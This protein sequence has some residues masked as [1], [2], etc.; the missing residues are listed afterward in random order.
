MISN[1]DAEDILREGGKNIRKYYDNPQFLKPQNKNIGSNLSVDWVTE[2][3][4]STQVL[5]TRLFRK[6]D[7]RC[8]CMGEEGRN[9]YISRILNPKNS[10]RTMYLVD[11]VDGTNNLKNGSKYFGTIVAEIR[12]CVT[13]RAWLHN[14]LTD[15]IMFAELGG[16]AYLNGERIHTAPKEALKDM[17]GFVRAKYCDEHVDNIRAVREQFNSSTTLGSCMHEY[18]HIAAGVIGNDR[19]EIENNAQFAA[20]TNTKLHDH[21]GGALIVT[22][23]GGV[24]LVRETGEPYTVHDAGKNVIVAAS[25]E[26]LEMV[27]ELLFSDEF[28]P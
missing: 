4:I 5:M 12:G 28:N 7:P 23:S 14:T 11:P 9:S 10:E 6:A 2:A 18:W 15:E 20:Y 17:K 3:D 8:W 24:A 19:R 22:E 13:T 16:G 27:K 26:N 21:L 25:R 1:E